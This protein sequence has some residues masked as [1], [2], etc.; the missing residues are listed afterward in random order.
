M[1]LVP[2]RVVA[3][4]ALLSASSYACGDEGPR[5]PAEVRVTE[6]DGQIAPVGTL[7]PQPIAIAV[8][9]A[10]GS[11]AP[12]VRVEWQADGDERLLATDRETDSNGQ[13]RARWQLGTS[14]GERRAQAV[15]PGLEPA[16]FTAIAEGPDQV[17]F[18][19]IIPLDFATYD[20]AHQ[21]VHPDF[22]ATPTGLFARPYHLAITP[23][24]YGNPAFENPSF[25]ESTRRSTWA[26]TEGAPNPVVKPTEGYLSDPDVVL[27][28]EAGEL[29]LYY[30]Q[31]TT[32]N[33]G[34]P[35]ADAG[36]GH[37]DG[38]G[39]GASRAEPS[40]HLAQRHPTGP[41]RLVDVRGQLGPRRLRRGQH[42]GGRPPL[43]GRDP[44]ERA[45]G[46]RAHPGGPLAVAHRRAV[47]PE[48]RRV[49]GAVQREEA[50]RGARRPRSTSPRARTDTPGPW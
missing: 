10:D 41:R 33:I 36:R 16:V 32:E 26:L 8:L 48:P 17:P 37:L 22:V 24:P 38:S 25:F 3:G 21:V 2:S 30:R 23:Y 42:H 49:L 44:L 50:R 43:V 35:D 47:D 27:L 14:E 18:D 39:H 5:P 13:A 31:V 1:H 19:E 6:G 9:N 11:P 28:P 40:G 20:G 46:H 15:L 29:W 34:P 7:L 12:G 4:V 45:P